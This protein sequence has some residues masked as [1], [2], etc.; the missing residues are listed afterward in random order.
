MGRY[1]KTAV[2]LF[3]C[4]FVFLNIATTIAVNFINII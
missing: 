3:D 1:K 4:G 2:V